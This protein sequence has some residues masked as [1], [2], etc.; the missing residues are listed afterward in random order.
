MKN[1]TCGSTGQK[2]EGDVRA[3]TVRGAPSR[4]R[5]RRGGVALARVGKHLIVSQIYNLACK[6]PQCSGCEEGSFRRLILRARAVLVVIARE[7]PPRRLITPPRGRRGRRKALAPWRRLSVG[8]RATATDKK[9]VEE[10]F[11]SSSS[12]PPL[13]PFHSSSSLLPLPS[14]PRPS[15]DP[16]SSSSSFPPFFAFVCREG[17][18]KKKEPPFPEG[19]K[20][21][22]REGRAIVLHF[23]QT[24]S[25]LLFFCCDRVRG[26]LS[27]PP[28]PQPMAPQPLRCRLPPPPVAHTTEDPSPPPPP[29]R[30][31]SSAAQDAVITLHQYRT[32]G[33]ERTGK[34]KPFSILRAGE[35]AFLFF[36]FSIQTQFSF[37][38]SPLLFSP[39]SLCP[40][41]DEE[42][43]FDLPL[44]HF[45]RPRDRRTTDD[46]LMDQKI[47]PKK[48]PPPPPLLDRDGNQGNGPKTTTVS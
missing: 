39:L 12:P 31:H 20:E 18:G 10:S 1:T 9:I 7:I 44:P 8:R 32:E 4:A 21:G 37:P 16:P 22:D 34:E 13:P 11:P 40:T 36:F 42:V 2:T 19:R 28:P 27:P 35:T 17:R 26:R 33:T 47:F 5:V 15:P 14:S 3:A 25:F 38:P 24:S 29:P 30:A 23:L 48:G 46:G 6:V 45:R 43:V 41:G